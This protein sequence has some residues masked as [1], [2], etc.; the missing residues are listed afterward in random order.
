MLEPVEFVL[1]FDE[2]NTLLSNLPFNQNKSA[3]KAETI[4]NNGFALISSPFYLCD[5]KDEILELDA[6]FNNSYV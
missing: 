5:I 2:V 1:E 6:S 3:A 4:T